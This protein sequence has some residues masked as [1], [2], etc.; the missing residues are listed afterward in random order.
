MKGLLSTLLALAWFFATHALIGRLL[1]ERPEL[2]LLPDSVE[3]QKFA[4]F[5]EHANDYDLVYVGTS[6][7]FRG[8]DP[9]LFDARLAELGHPLRSY[10]FGLVG[11]NYLEERFLTEWVLAHR[12][13]RLRQLL[14][15]P[16]E[17]G[18]LLTRANLFTLRDVNWHTPQ[19]TLRALDATWRSGAS[20]A[21]KFEYA[22]AH[23]LHGLHRLCNV[24]L[25]AGLLARL[26]APVS[27]HP[28]LPA[29]F[30]GIDSELDLDAQREPEASTEPDPDEP[31]AFL[32]QTYAEITA[33]ASAAG[34]APLY[35][36]PPANISVAAF[37]QA[38][39][40]GAL[41]NLLLFP[42]RTLPELLADPAAYYYGGGHLNA[43]GAALFSRRLAERYAHFLERAR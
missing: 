19:D 35:V 29:G 37:T 1:A 33:R 8:F 23:L 9:A 4:H 31:S 11:L 7:V 2:R 32:W 12:G 16:T 40:R 3:A 26:F 17:R 22:R 41:P 38:A 34:L 43:R 42:L 5:R 15:E 30:E 14:I 24:G 10:N 6:R 36:I 20:P 25:G 18:V 39:D 28:P 21:R 13:E 27:A